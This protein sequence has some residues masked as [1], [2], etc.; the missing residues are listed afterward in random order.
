MGV[1]AHLPLSAC[2]RVLLTLV[3]ILLTLASGPACLT[4]A[5]S[6]GLAARGTAVTRAG[7][8]T[9]GAV[10]QTGARGAGALIRVEPK[11]AVTGAVEASLCVVTRLR[12][13]TVLTL[14]VVPARLVVCGVQVVPGM[15]K[16][17]GDQAAGIRGVLRSAAVLTTTAGLTDATSVLR[18]NTGP[19]RVV[20]GVPFF[21]EA[22]VAPCSIAADLLTAGRLLRA[23]VDVRTGPEVVGELVASGAG[24]LVAACRVDAGHLA[25]MM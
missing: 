23:L 9:P 17:L 13:Q 10:S 4:D 7:Q 15:T 16:T 19:L 3:Y 22:P 20:Q 5:A 2:A 6:D 18:L 21:T 11:A 8:L 14:V 24:A 12:A 1:A 25:G